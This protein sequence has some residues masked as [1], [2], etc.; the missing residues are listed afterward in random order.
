MILFVLYYCQLEN[1]RRKFG[2]G[3]NLPQY[4]AILEKKQSSFVY[5]LI[6]TKNAIFTLL[7]FKKDFWKDINHAHGLRH[8]WCELAV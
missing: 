5:W 3:V 1:P 7:K 8:A 2:E 4:V 6:N